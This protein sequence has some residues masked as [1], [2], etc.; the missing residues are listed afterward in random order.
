MKKKIYKLGGVALVLA[1]IAVLLLATMPV[2]AVSYAK[3]DW[4]KYQV[5]EQGKSG[6]YVLYEDSDVGPIAVT[7][8]GTLY[9]YVNHDGDDELFKSTDGGHTWDM[10]ED[11][12]G[13][14]VIDIAVS[15]VDPDVVFFATADAVYKTTDAGDK[16][17]VKSTSGYVAGS[18]TSMDVTY[19]N[20]AY[21]IVI[22]AEDTT[23]G[24]V[25]L[26]DESETI[27]SWSDL[28]VLL[29]GDVLDV[30]VSPFF[31]EDRQI[32]A[33][34]SDGTDV[35]I[36]T[37]VE[38]G[39]WNGDVADS[40]SIPVTAATT[41]SIVFPDD[42]DADPDSGD[43][44]QFIGVGDGAGADGDVGVYLLT[45]ILYDGIN[46]SPVTAMAT[47]TTLGAANFDVLELDIEGDGSSGT[48]VA[49]LDQP[50][51]YT[52]VVAP[53]GIAQVW[54]TDDGGN[55]W[56][57]AVKPPSGRTD[58]GAGIT[59]T[60]THV[61]L[62]GDTVY[63]STFGMDS[64]FSVSD[65]GGETFTQPGLIDSVIGTIKDV[66]ASSGYPNASLYM[67]AG[68]GLWVTE[69]Q[70]GEWNRIL[71]EGLTMVLSPTKKPTVGIMSNITQAADNIWVRAE[72]VV[73]GTLSCKIWKSD[74]GTVFTPLKTSAPYQL[75]AWSIVDESEIWVARFNSGDLYHTTNG[76][77]S[78]GSPKDTGLSSSGAP[79]IVAILG[80]R[81]E[82]DYW[83]V[84]GPSMDDI[85]YSEDGGDT[86]EPV[87]IDDARPGA[88]GSFDGGFMNAASAGYQTIWGIGGADG[89]G[90]YV[91]GESSE[92]EDIIDEPSIQ[93]GVV[94][95]PIVAPDPD[96]T[97]YATLTTGELLRAVEPT[98]RTY[99]TSPDYELDPDDYEEVARSGDYGLWFSI[100]ADSVILF[101]RDSPDVLMTLWDTL[102]VPGKLTAPEDGGSSGRQSSGT[103]SWA[104][105]DGADY[106][107]VEWDEDPSFK[108]TPDSLDTLEVSNYRIT[109]LESGRTYY[110][111][112]RVAKGEPYLS[113]WSETWS[114]TTELGAP[115]WN[116]FIGG[117]PEAPYNGAT[118]V[119]IQPTFAWNAADW[120]TGYEFILAKDPAF[121]DTVVS[122]TGANALTNTVYL[123]EVQLDN[124]MTY[125]WKVRAIS[126]TSNSEWANAVFTTEA[127]AP[128]PPPPPPTPT[129]TPTPA[130]VLTQA[131]IW[132][133]IGIGVIL[134]IAL[135]V[136]IVRTRRVA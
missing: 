36:T 95:P 30:A 48:I 135:I 27:G 6:D 55:S 77:V 112:S 132:T 45:G 109:G 20:D 2:S 72:D 113:P 33:A 67:L 43:Y 68:T 66:N 81:G 34:V 102:C 92:W 75:S 122:K 136:L 54:R 8:D 49:G 128:A 19:F 83:I 99:G 41:A 80:L 59:M 97:L 96:G 58:T 100:Q 90:R 1:L 17:K 119:P 94:I 53:D 124:S 39:S 60:K 101:N 111:H 25:F 63:A 10:L 64:G 129:P 110:W 115:Q 71:S 89:V 116:P 51:P 86:W 18:I 65:D 88:V 22:G 91:L 87:D 126:K 5:P 32:V 24:E 114:F 76:G 120:A 44:M 103:V 56:D 7:S 117:V 78:W 21:I 130:P 118:N 31:E 107:E 84:G 42:Y 73:T 82:P 85:A 93:K 47:E 3:N 37:M 26:F 16:F 62:E 123:C 61:V 29:S 125:Y 15:S 4:K 46:D 79:G 14:E 35:I 50:S 23:D 9:A 127:A 52:P 104:E 70:G 133:I 134:V 57:E 38:G 28:D 11:Y 12:T 121:T 69:D 40:E 108:V 74:D 98:D 106:Y 131:I 105:R 13:G